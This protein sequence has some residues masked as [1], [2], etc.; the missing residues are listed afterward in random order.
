MKSKLS[1]L[2]VVLLGLLNWGALF[3]DDLNV[4]RLSSFYNNWLNTQGVAVSGNFAYVTAIGD[5]NVIDVTD[6]VKPVVI[7]S[8]AIANNDYGPYGIVLSDGYLYIPAGTEGM[9]IVDISEPTQPQEVGCWERP[10]VN[11]LKVKG[12]NV[13]LLDNMT[14]IEV[15]DISEPTRPEEISAFPI[16]SNL[17]HI[18]IAGNFAFVSADTAGL[19]I[20]DITEPA[21]IHK[22]GNFA[23]YSR[24]LHS[25]VDGNYVYIADEDSGLCIVDITDPSTPQLASHLTFEWLTHPIIQLQ[26]GLLYFG[27]GC[28]V[29]IVDITDR[30]NPKIVGAGEVG[31]YI[32]DMEVQDEF[33]HVAT[34]NDV[35]GF[36]YDGRGGLRILDISKPEAVSEVG[37]C[38]SPGYVWDVAVSGN[39]AYVAD[40]DGGLRCVDITNPAI[41]AEIGQLSFYGLK[42]LGV[43]VFG[44]FVF[45][46]AVFCGITVINVVDPSNPAIVGSFGGEVAEC[47]VVLNGSYAYATN[48][49]GFISVD[50][51]DPSK[52]QTVGQY[53]SDGYCQSVAVNDRIACVGLGYEGLR[54]VDV[55]DPATPTELGSLVLVGTADRV[56]ISGNLAFVAGENRWLRF[57]DIS[58]PSAPKIMNEYRTPIS[59]NRITVD[60][61]FLFLSGGGGFRIV[62]FSDP[63]NPVETGHG[64]FYSSNG[65]AVQGDI[66]YVSEGRNLAVYDCQNATAVSGGASGTQPSGVSLDTNY[67]NPFNSSTTIRYG[68][69]VAG[70]VRLSLFDTAGRLVEQIV[71]GTVPAGYHSVTWNGINHPAGLYILRLEA[72]G[73]IKTAKMVLVK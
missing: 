71:T 18:E 50:I 26:G 72:G 27:D 64:S 67:P 34:E 40:D 19:V 39:I 73:V 7:G 45:A 53:V 33:L 60:G 10:V 70:E 56:A 51:T 59:I 32:V 38:N 55:T 25:A 63:L 1:L 23:A 28:T 8:C 20:L 6:P 61:N 54:I 46:S 13:Y 52:P 58:Q 11:A 62:D 43:E 68:V 65:I 44:D 9:R 24:I 21:L 22:T 69:P 66:A 16:R 14:G 2:F 42:V 4:E 29:W 49:K 3:A 36:F 37:F 17:H 12:N 30:V 48:S 5:L 35:L 57:V 41:P 31:G 15:L 47:K